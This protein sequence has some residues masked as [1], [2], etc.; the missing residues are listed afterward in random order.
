VLQ[1]S[2]TTSPSRLA[3][4]C[5]WNGWVASNVLSLYQW[6]RVHEQSWVLTHS[7]VVPGGTDSMAP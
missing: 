2:P 3:L 6:R 4:G 1:M 7:M 5:D